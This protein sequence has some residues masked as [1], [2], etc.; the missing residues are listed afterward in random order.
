MYII[1]YYRTSWY[2]H[3]QVIMM[4]W[5]VDSAIEAK[6]EKLLLGRGSLF[7]LTY[8]L[9]LLLSLVLLLLPV[10]R[11]PPPFVTGDVPTG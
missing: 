1:S 5:V 9:L 11:S 6:T 3:I 10:L 2:S 4:R 7:V 8:P